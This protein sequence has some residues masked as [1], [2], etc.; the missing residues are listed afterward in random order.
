MNYDKKTERIISVQASKWTYSD[1]KHLA[2]TIKEHPEDMELKNM[3]LNLD[4]RTG[5]YCN[6]QLYTILSEIYCWLLHQYNAYYTLDEYVE[7]VSYYIFT[8]SFIDWRPGVEF[9]SYLKVAS[10]PHGAIGRDIRRNCYLIDAIPIDAYSDGDGFLNEALMSTDTQFSEG[11]EMEQ[12]IAEILK[13]VQLSD[14]EMQLL[15]ESSHEQISPE[16]VEAINRQFNTSYSSRE[17]ALIRQNAHRRIKYHYRQL[18]A[19]LKKH[20]GW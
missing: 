11:I 1:L 15:V 3:F 6:I 2:L 13:I 14:I 5:D 16:L 19:L 20:R 18:Q 12:L 17:I 8:R 7:A 4:P 10:M 9:K